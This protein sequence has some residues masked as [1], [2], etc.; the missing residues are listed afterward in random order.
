MYL[1]CYFV[2]S[3]AELNTLY[4][5]YMVCYFVPNLAEL[6]TLYVMYLEC[7]FQNNI[8]N[9]LHMMCLVMLG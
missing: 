3:L 7:Y 6:N 2:P 4:V 8:L 5:M 9:T 1:E